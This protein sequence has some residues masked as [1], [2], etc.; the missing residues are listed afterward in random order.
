M[1][2]M[3][4]SALRQL[5]GNPAFFCRPCTWAGWLMSLS[6]SCHVTGPSASCL[7][8][9]PSMLRLFKSLPLLPS[10]SSL[11]AR[12]MPPLLLPRPWAA[13]APCGA[14][15]G[16]QNRLT[17]LCSALCTALSCCGAPEFRCGPPSTMKDVLSVRETASM[18]K[19]ATATLPN[20]S[21]L[22]GLRATMVAMLHASGW[23]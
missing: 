3:C 18:I 2:T 5:A 10:L 19:P 23:L 21:L 13:A 7:A 4:P 9:C 12:A 14:R 22:L 20:G 11:P 16:V 8:P 1:L 17:A 15:G 6:I